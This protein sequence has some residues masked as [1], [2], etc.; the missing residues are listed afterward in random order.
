[1][2]YL[3]DDGCSYDQDIERNW[4]NVLNDRKE[5]EDGLVDWSL[6]GFTV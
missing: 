2:E 1:M 5:D 4:V 3:P 6:I